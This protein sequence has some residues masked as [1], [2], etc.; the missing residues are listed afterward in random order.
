MLP[1]GGFLVP[2][3]PLFFVSASQRRND[4]RRWRDVAILPFAPPRPGHATGAAA[5]RA[6]AAPAAADAVA[7]VW[8]PHPPRR[9][10]ADRRRRQRRTA[11]ER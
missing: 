8:L 5:S 6:A 11:H 10:R 2:K 1:F 4:T 3:A 7:P 9:R